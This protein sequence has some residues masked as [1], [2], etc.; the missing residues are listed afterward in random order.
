[1]TTT[2]P[3]DLIRAAAEA[4]S[5]GRTSE[6]TEVT[7]APEREGCMAYTAGSGVVMVNLKEPI[8][9]TGRQAAQLGSAILEHSGDFGLTLAQFGVLAVL[10]LSEAEQQEAGDAG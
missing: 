9:L 7:A 2:T 5:R 6:G 3:E 4:A 10:D 1:M 8:A